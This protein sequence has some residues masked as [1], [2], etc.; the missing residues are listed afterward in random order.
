MTAQNDGPPSP[1][2]SLDTEFEEF[3]AR[4]VEGLSHQVRGD[5]PPFQEVWSHA[6]DVSILGAVG[7]YAQGWENVSAHLFG[8]SR[9]LDWTGLSVQRLLTSAS[10]DLAVTVVLE[11]MTREVD[12]KPDARTLRTTQAYR[13]ENGE[14]RLILRHANPVGPDD[15]ARE[16]AL[17]ADE[18]DRLRGGPR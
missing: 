18:R 15:E 5:S 16:R 9:S 11:H 13:R 6:D 3:V 12:G 8:A 14:W 2:G 17:L 7:S 1:P 4:C 10:G